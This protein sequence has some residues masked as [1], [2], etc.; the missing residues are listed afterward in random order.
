MKKLISV[1]LFFSL[2]F[3]VSIP[4]LASEYSVC[5]TAEFTS[6]SGV[7]RPYSSM[8]GYARGT[9]SSSSPHLL[10]WATASGIGGMG[11]TV[12]C[13]CSANYRIGMYLVEENSRLLLDN[14]NVYTNQEQYFNDLLHTSG[15][16]YVF[17]FVDIPAGVSFDC[18]IWI[19]G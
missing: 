19:Y 3:V 5:Q 9:I 6:D 17:T 12:K 14:V 8:D 2:V 13:S 15:A 18:Q 16:Y 10:V 7:I 4:A 11:V 1:L